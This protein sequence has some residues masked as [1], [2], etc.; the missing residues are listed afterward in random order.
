MRRLFWATLGATAG[1]FVVRKLNRTAQAYTPEGISRSL[2]G[3]AAGLRDVADAVREGMADRERE[4]RVAL[5]VDAGDLDADSAR[6]L[7]DRPAA[8]RL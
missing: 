6:D 7:L 1:V 5:G 3:V 2:A 4:L 8:R